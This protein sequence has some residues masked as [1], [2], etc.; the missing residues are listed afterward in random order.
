M[1]KN[2]PVPFNLFYPRVPP[3]PIKPSLAYACLKSVPLYPDTALKQIEYLRPIFEW[4]STLDYLK[5][6]PAGYLSESVDVLGELDKIAANLR[7]NGTKQYKNEFDFL[8]DLHTLTSVRV[9]D[10]HFSYSTLLLDLFTFQMGMEFVSIS[11]DGLALPEIFLRCK[12]T[13]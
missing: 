4:H 2:F 5:N 8:S 12:R 1:P 6:P 9:R 7:G 11:K 10:V 3:A 13:T